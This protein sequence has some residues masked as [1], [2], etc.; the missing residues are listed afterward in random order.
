VYDLNTL[1]GNLRGWLAGV[2]RT[3][4]VLFDGQKHVGLAAARLALQRILDQPAVASG[5]PQ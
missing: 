1:T 3:P 4:S 5:L 2:R